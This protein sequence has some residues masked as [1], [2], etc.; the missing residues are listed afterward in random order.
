MLRRVK[1]RRSSGT[2]SKSAS[3]KI[4]TVYSLAHILTRT[5]ASPK[6]TSYEGW[7]HR[8]LHRCDAG[9]RIAAPVIPETPDESDC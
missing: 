1:R 3:T 9:V 4:S 8:R 6:S 5:G 7:I 2:I